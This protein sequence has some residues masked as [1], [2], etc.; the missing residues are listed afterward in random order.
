MWVNKVGP[1]QNPQESYAYYDLPYCQPAEHEEWA[2]SL[3]EAL[4]GYELVQSDMVVP[5]KGARPPL[6]IPLTTTAVDVQTK[7]L[8]S[9]TLTAH[10]ADLFRRAIKRNYWFQM[11]YG[12]P[13]LLLL[14][15]L[16]LMVRLKMIYLS[17]A[18]SARPWSRRAIRERSPRRSFTLTASSQSATMA[19]ASSR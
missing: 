1:F 19:I 10:E 6:S 7:Q 15:V 3:G 16:D 4:Q 5:F 13:L 2:E 14:P 9:K 18:A 12:A 17:G 8:C 11:F